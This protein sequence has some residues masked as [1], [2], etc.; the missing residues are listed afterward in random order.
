MLPHKQCVSSFGE[1]QNPI[2]LNS[3]W[4]RSLRFGHAGHALHREHAATLKDVRAEVLTPERLKSVVFGVFAALELAIA[5]VGVA[6]VLAFLVGARTQEFGIRL[7]SQPGK[8][9]S[10]R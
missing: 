4:Y 9:R 6:G 10:S 8:P 1:G 3:Q 2:P 5:V 7:G